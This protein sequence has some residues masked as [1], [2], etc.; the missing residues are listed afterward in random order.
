MPLSIIGCPVAIWLVYKQY[1]KPKRFLRT[2]F[3]AYENIYYK[4]KEIK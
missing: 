1:K 4:G 2:G 3:I